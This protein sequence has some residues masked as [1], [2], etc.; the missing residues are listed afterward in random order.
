MLRGLPRVAALRC[1]RCSRWAGE[2]AERL[3]ERESCRRAPAACTFMLPLAI[4]FFFFAGCASPSQLSLQ[5][6]FPLAI[7]PLASSRSLSLPLSLFS[8]RRR[9]SAGTRL[10]AA[11]VPAAQCPR[12]RAGAGAGAEGR[13]GSC[14]SATCQER[15]R[16]TSALEQFIG[17]QKRRGKGSCFGI[18]FQHLLCSSHSQRVWHYSGSVG[19]IFFFLFPLPHPSRKRM[20]SEIVS[21]TH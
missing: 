7:A 8:Q 2:R 18:S 10:P 9:S 16:L 4:D 13:A 11:P 20:N 5:L 19:N 1:G 14:P 21:L 3:R 6:A 12:R 17:T 15:R